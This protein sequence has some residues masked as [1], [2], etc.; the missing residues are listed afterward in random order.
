MTDILGTYFKGITQKLQKY[1]FFIR[2]TLSGLELVQFS[3]NLD[4][5]FLFPGDVQLFCTSSTRESSKTPSEEMRRLRLVLSFNSWNLKHQLRHIANAKILKNVLT[6]N[7]TEHCKY[8]YKTVK[9]RK[10]RTKQCA[11]NSAR[12]WALNQRSKGRITA[13]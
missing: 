11:Y 2:H 3:G 13:C 4:H 9:T 8:N 10:N 7:S 6:K 1:F 5:W 12:N